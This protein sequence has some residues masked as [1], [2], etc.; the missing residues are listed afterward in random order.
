MWSQI[1]A[2]VW[3]QLRTMRNHLPR[4]NTGTLL[5]WLLFLLWYGMYAGFGVAL[6]IWVPEVG[7]PDLRRWMPVGLLAVFFFWQLIPLFS[8]STGWSLQLKR[9][10]VYPISNGTLFAIEI[11][12]R[13]TTAPEMILVLL[14]AT[15]GLLRHPDIPFFAPFFLLL[16]IPFNLLLSLAVREL[17]LHSFRRN[18]FRELFAILLI[19]VGVIPQVLVRTGLGRK[20]EPYV[21]SASAGTGTPW[22]EIAMLGLGVFSVLS[23]VLTILWISICYGIAKW[24]FAKSVVQD[25]TPLRRSAIAVTA[26]VRRAPAFTSILDLPGKIFRDPVGALLQKELR[27]LVRMPR[28]RVMFGMACLFSVVIFLPSTLRGGGNSFMA[29]NFVPLANLYGLLLLGEVVLWNVFGFD[30]R[31][32]QLY[33]VAPL[34]FEA[35][36]KAKNLTAIAFMALQ[37]LIVSAIAVAVRIAITPLSITTAF[38]ATAVVGIFFLSLGNLSSIAIPRA[39]DPAQTFRKQ[40]GGKMQL[41]FALSSLGMVILIGFAF[42]ARW[43]LQS[44][45]ALFGIFAI[46]FAIGVIVYRIATESALQRGIQERERIIDALSRTGSPISTLGLS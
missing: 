15:V 1:S 28:F 3:A 27:S 44:N 36:L 8:L 18:R 41:W 16:Y 43:A 11:F 40:A 39:V 22:H 12:L 2:I 19:S 34:P 45:W 29:T 9:L 30:A 14:G 6:A 35:V 46:E 20:I 13:L 42:L 7:V 5:G 31:A 26:S 24:Q 10:C 25:E 32:A 37:T 23:L 33:F 38:A 4:T 21:I 17:L